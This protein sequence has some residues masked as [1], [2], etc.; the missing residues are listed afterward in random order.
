M[1]KVIPDRVCTEK[2]SPFYDAQIGREID[3]FLNGIRQVNN[4]V[5][6]CISEGWLRRYRK[7]ALGQVKTD[8]FHQPIID[9]VEGTVTVEWRA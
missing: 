4:V 7:T 1:Q 9:R 2:A 6:Y 5:E 3:V 8:E